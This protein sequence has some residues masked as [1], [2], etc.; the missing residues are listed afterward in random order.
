MG[1]LAMFLSCGLVINTVSAILVQQI[2]QIGI[3]RSVG[4]V[5]W[6]VV[7]MYL[8][9]V[10]VFSILGLV[11]AIPLGLAGAWWLT[12]FAASFLNFDIGQ[13][14]LPPVFCSN[15]CFLGL[16][17]PAG[18]ALIPILA[19]TRL[20]VYDAIYN[21]DWVERRMTGLKRLLGKLR[22]LNPPILLP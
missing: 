3:L 16:I 1:I 2:K 6:Q 5:R 17:M 19:G 15:N 20:S 12:N 21:M 11:I 10:L 4:A 9:N 18:I 13:I 22:R 8:F 7:R 14:D